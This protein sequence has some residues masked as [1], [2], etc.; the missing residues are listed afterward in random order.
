MFE[1]EGEDG[2][3]EEA[4]VDDVPSEGG[5]TLDS[6]GNEVDSELTPS[7][8]VDVN[9]G[10]VEESSDGSRE[11]VAGG[12]DV[13]AGEA[14]AEM[15]GEPISTAVEEPASKKGPRAT[16]YQRDLIIFRDELG[17]LLTQKEKL[18]LQWVDYR[19]DKAYYDYWQRESNRIFRKQVLINRRLKKSINK[20][21]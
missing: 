13:E 12:P 19:F 6:N 2:D 18:K 4:A 9:E 8:H 7:G 15:T 11:E 21:G 5:E 3:K 10:P 20:T 16:P 1:D 14:M 17:N